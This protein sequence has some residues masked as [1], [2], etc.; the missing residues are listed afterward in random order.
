MVSA[1]RTVG[2]E[3]AAVHTVL[4][5]VLTGRGIRTDRASGRNVVS[6]DRIAQLREHACTDDIGNRIGVYAHAL[7]VRW[8]AHVRGGVIPV[9]DIAL[10]GVEFAPAIIAGENEIGRA[11]CRER[12]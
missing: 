6:G 12:V 5:Q 3:I 10:G 8:L 1:T 11:S 7:E 4:L 9:E 2:V